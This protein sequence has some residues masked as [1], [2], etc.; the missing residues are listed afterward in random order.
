MAMKKTHYYH[1]ICSI[2]KL[3]NPTSWATMCGLRVIKKESKRKIT[4]DEEKVT[5]KLCRSLLFRRFVD[6]L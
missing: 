6:K 4:R 2:S 1:G 3:Q 5:C